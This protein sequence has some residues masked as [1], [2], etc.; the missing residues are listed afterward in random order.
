MSNNNYLPYHPDIEGDDEEAI[1]DAYL[2]KIKNEYKDQWTEENW[3]EEMEKHPFFMT[4]MPE[5]GEA[6]PPGVEAMQQLKWDIENET[7]AEKALAYKEEGNVHFKNK[8]YKKAIIS[9]TEG[10]KQ[11][12]EATEKE[13]CSILHNNRASAHFHLGNYRSAFNDTV[14]A[15]KFNRANVKAVY[16][17]AEC[18]LK[19]KMFDDAIKWCETVLSI[20]PED[21]KAKELRGLI[22]ITKKTELK[23]K[24]KKEAA[25][26][27]VTEKY[28][29]I[30]DLINSRGI[31]I[32]E[33]NEKF[34][35]LLENPVNPVS[36]CVQVAED[37]ES[38]KWPC[39][40]LYPEFGQTEFIEA[41]DEY[42]IFEDHLK[43][44]FSEAPDWDTSKTY[45]HDNLEVFY[46]NQ[47]NHKLMKVP[48]SATLLEILK[49]EGHIIQL[50]TP[51]FLLMVK[52]SK[53]K[54]MYIEKYNEMC[55]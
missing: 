24:R 31:Q 44:M 30:L 46:E 22:E 8:Q 48:N 25:A 17:G 7:P 37:G 9:Y 6:L 54:K 16:R 10:L 13:L 14:F 50:G 36:K 29:K 51:K 1:M 53:F 34:T 52:D 19:L 42:S 21:Q 18:C 5:E 40:L 32:Q 23:E 38:L 35:N 28:K 33:S 15:R 11:K 3:E 49:K 12:I 45:T 26:R 4:K 47:K 39:V 27:K 55:L 20:N 41:F 43:V 2:D